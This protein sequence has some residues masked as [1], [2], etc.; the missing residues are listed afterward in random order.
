MALRIVFCGTPAFGLP[1]LARLLA[2]SDFSVEAVITQPDRPSGRGQ[3]TSTS[4]VKD[5]AL[6]AGIRVFQPEKIRSD[7]ARDFLKRLAPDAVVIIAY[8]QIIPR[9]LLE[10]PRLGWINLHASL[11]PQYRGAAPI[12]RA[13]LNGDKKS[14]LTTMKIDAGMDT[15]PVL[16]QIEM[17]I[18]ADETAQQ[19]AERMAETGAPL[20]LGTLRN[21]QLGKIQPKPQDNAKATLAPPLKKEEGLID[22]SRPA[23]GVYNQIRAFDPWPGAFTRFRER[24]CHIWG[25]PAKLPQGGKRSEPGTILADKENVLVVCGGSSCLAIGHVKPEGRKRV[26]AR[27]FASGARFKPGERFSS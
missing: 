21:L 11:L 23:S 18:G 1:T 6:A 2:D 27:E 26:T 19:L 16:E 12:Q 7:A 14:G 15:G 22:W 24:V 5:A 9:D 13:I 10:I 8:G 25:R 17:E 4:P 3:K 20:M